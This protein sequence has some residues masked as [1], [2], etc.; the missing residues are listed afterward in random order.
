MKKLLFIVPSL[1]TGG[2][3]SSLI[4]IH[5]VLGSEYLFY[6]YPLVHEGIKNFTPSNKIL[7]KNKLVHLYN[8]TYSKTKNI[9]KFEAFII[10]VL[11]RLSILFKF[12][13]EYY[14]YK[15]AIKSIHA[16]KYD[17]VIGFQ[18]GSATYFASLMHCK[19]KIAWIHCDYSKYPQCNKEFYT[20]D[21][22]NKIIC[23][24][25]YTANVFSKI[26][27]QLKKRTSY[28]YNLLNIDEIIHK[29]KEKINDLQLDNKIFTILS[30]GR[31]STVKRFSLI[32]SVANTLAKHGINFRWIIIG[33]NYNDKCYKELLDNIKLYNTENNVF[34]LG[35]KNNP[36]PYFQN[37]DLL[38]SL[39]E[40][41]ACPMI[42]NEA[43]ILKLP[44]ITTDFPTSYEFITEKNYGKIVPLEQ[45]S[46]AIIN[47]IRHSTHSYQSNSSLE[48]YNAQ[49]I[50][51]IHNLFI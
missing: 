4:S 46:E 10:K 22:F 11:K 45:I 6:I 48:D 29:S 24:S 49:I 36:Y 30:V 41:E 2:T 9:E 5:D 14:I 26:Y 32:P 35:N 28:I 12:N 19:Q 44:I 43:K 31:I 21:K 38:V 20:Y 50:K 3:L 7:K 16:E 51:D 27:P 33:P 42:F 17:Y 18:E 8:C 13:L 1:E 25:L 37:S 47:H 23:V 39:S 34:Y 15:R 40:T